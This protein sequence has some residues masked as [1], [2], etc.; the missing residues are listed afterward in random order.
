MPGD[1][2]VRALVESPEYRARAVS[3]KTVTLHDHDFVV[4]AEVTM[5]QEDYEPYVF[6]PLMGFYETRRNVPRRVC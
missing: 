3:L 6:H 1:A 4:H 2:I 5:Y